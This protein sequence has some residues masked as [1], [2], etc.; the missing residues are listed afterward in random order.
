MMHAGT[1]RFTVLQQSVQLPVKSEAVRTAGSSKRD[2]HQCPDLFQE[3]AHNPASSESVIREETASLDQIH[4][5]AAG[6]YLFALM[7]STDQILVPHKAKELGSPRAISLFSGTAKEQYWQVAPYLFQVDPG[8]L[9][10]I[11]A[12]LWTEPWGIF[13]ISK[14]NFE[15]LRIHFKKFLLV[16]LPDGKV[17]FFRYYD[18]R[19]LKVYLPACEPWELQ[20]L[21]GP[22]RAFATAGG[23][24]EKITMVQGPKLHFQQQGVREGPG[25]WWKIRHEQRI[26]FKKAAM[27][28]F[29]LRLMAHVNEFFPEECKE[30]S[31]PGVRA[32]LEHCIERAASYQII[33]ERDICRYIDV[34]FAFG[35]DFD[36]D[37]DIPWARRI[38]RRKDCTPELKVSYL[39]D[40]V[41]LLAQSEED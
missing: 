37:P 25:I 15:E 28:S 41:D 5:F 40:E 1:P 8:L 11:L 35:R 26:A 16:Q 24:Q 39:L 17:W 13:A 10:W 27:E 23:Q 21:F 12:K 33:S 36:V 30:L 29:M 2:Q 32:T 22:V 19:I 34:A 31:P 14:A 38:L 4:R 3:M 9:D 20:K 7:D 18:P 6:G